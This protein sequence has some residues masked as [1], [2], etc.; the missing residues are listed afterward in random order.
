MKNLGRVKIRGFLTDGRPDP[1]KILIAI[2]RI[3]F[4]SR[5][6]LK[7]IVCTSTQQNVPV[8]KLGSKH[9]SVTFIILKAVLVII[10]LPKYTI[11]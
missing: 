11:L 10:I 7:L 9:H 1:L 4:K 3:S 2:V 6:L 5:T 8:G